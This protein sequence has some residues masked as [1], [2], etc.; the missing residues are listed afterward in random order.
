MG[1]GGV[2]VVKLPV[3][4]SHSLSVYEDLPKKVAPKLLRNLKASVCR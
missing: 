4:V 1:G 3:C 2:K